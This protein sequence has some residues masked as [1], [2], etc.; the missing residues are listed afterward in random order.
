MRFGAVASAAPQRA[1]R[2]GRGWARVSPL[3]NRD[4]GLSGTARGAIV[5]G[6]LR[7]MGLG[8]PSVL[9]EEMARLSRVVHR[10]IWANPLKNFG[11]VRTAHPGDAGR[12]AARGRIRLGIRSRRWRD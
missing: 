2:A 3:F 8:D 12:V 9:A 4:W 6:V 10:T 11:G 7:R 1:Q 5:V